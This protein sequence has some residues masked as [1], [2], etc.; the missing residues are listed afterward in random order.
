M[1]FGVAVI[2]FEKLG[3]AVICFNGFGIAVIYVM[4]FGI[5][6]LYLIKFGAAVIYRYFRTSICFTKT[7][8]VRVIRYS[9]QFPPVVFIFLYRFW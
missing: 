4:K 3:I 7:G 6:V 5:E 8:A 2:S 9:G 1:K